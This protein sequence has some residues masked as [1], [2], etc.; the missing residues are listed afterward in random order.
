MKG[1]TKFKPHKRRCEVKLVRHVEGRKEE[2]EEERRRHWRR[3]NGEEE[4]RR[5]KRKK[6]RRWKLKKKK[7]IEITYTLACVLKLVGPWIVVNNKKMCEKYYLN[8]R[9]CKID[10]LT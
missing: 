1:C 2:K 8:K 9:K 7:E 5:R 3:K 6:R 10:K 4:R